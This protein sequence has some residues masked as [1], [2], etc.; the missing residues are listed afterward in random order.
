MGVQRL[1][2]MMNE[3]LQNTFIVLIAVP[4]LGILMGG[5]YSVPAMR[6][7]NCRDPWF[8]MLLAAGLSVTIV[9]IAIG[10]GL[11]VPLTLIAWAC[12]CAGLLVRRSFGKLDHNIERF[13][14]IHAASLVGMLWLVLLA[15]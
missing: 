7:T 2:E 12:A 14:L 3:K 9:A 10:C 1:C 13:G 5:V 6:V 4:V 11:A 8:T 15:R